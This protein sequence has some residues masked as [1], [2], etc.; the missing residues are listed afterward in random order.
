MLVYANALQLVG[1]DAFKATAGAIHGWLNDQLGQK[2]SLA[3][4]LR[5]GQWNSDVGRKS[6][7]LH[8]YAATGEDPEMYAWSL[9]HLDDDV[10]GRQW[11]V[12]IG[13]KQERDVIDFSC[14]VQTEEM[15][16]LIT[17]G[18]VATRPRLIRYLLDNLE[19]AADAKFAV[20]TPGVSLKTVGDNP[21]SYRGLLADIVR[22]ERNYPIVL[23]SP[24]SDGM[25][26]IGPSRLQEALLGL[27]Q[28]V[29]VDAGFN[30]WDMEEA[31]GRQFSAWGG[32]VNVIRTPGKDGAVRSTFSLSHEVEGWGAT[33]GERVAAVLARVTHATNVPRL[34][35]RIRPDGVAR[36]AMVRRMAQQRKELLGRTGSDQGMLE[37]YKNDL[38][39]MTEQNQ[40]LRSECDDKELTNMQLQEDKDRLDQ[41]LREERYKNRQLMRRSSSGTEPSVDPSL[42]LDLASRGDQPSPKEC[43]EAIQQAYPSRVTVLESAYDTAGEHARF[44][45]GRRLLRLLMTL[46]TDYIDKIEAGG[47]NAARKCFTVDEYAATESESTQANTDMRR[48]RTFT[49]DDR[50]IEMYRHLRVGKADDERKSIRV[51]FEWLPVEKK[52]VIGHCGKHLPIISH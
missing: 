44:D 33:Q 24:D 23:I 27:A 19:R 47:D 36:L 2:L 21:D 31:L 46:C 6:A 13:V 22:L 12:E 32:A 11:L 3:E 45:A 9:K 48:K 35:K 20:G 8:V 42:F 34:R 1:S 7:W 28:V 49:H 43:L 51:Y 4:I 38:E 29:Q 26:L 52:I 37:L 18:V 41:D 16:V 14:T 50:P 40:Q 17:Q 39:E 10:S 30:S 15:S 5:S 25:Y